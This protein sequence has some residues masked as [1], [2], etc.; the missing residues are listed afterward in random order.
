MSIYFNSL[1]IILIIST[2]IWLISI[3]I[4]NASIVDIFWG[5]GF[6]ITNGYYFYSSDNHSVIQYI[7]LG[8]VTIWG[9]RLTIYIFWRNK[10]KGEDFRYQ[11]FRKD[12]GPKRY[13]WVSFFQTFMLQ[14]VLIWIIS[15]T[16]WNINVS[17]C[18][19]INIL[20]YLGLLVWIIGFVFEAGGDYQLSK[21]KSNPQNKGKLLT[22]GLW[23]YT[24]HPNYFGDAAVWW[25]YALVSLGLGGTW[26]IVG[27]LIMTFLLLKVSGV[28]LLEKTMTKRAGYE[29]YITKT[30]SFIPWFPKR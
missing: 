19:S 30:S 3:A 20:I 26:H 16:L 24:R 14:G 9:L 25:G 15:I 2:T 29:D 8:L 10:G 18:A 4:T 27:S 28:R 22:T 17:V 13:W 7:I 21:F 11:Q 5:T 6:V 12:F 23:R 1:V